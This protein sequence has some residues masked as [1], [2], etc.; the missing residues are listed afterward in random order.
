[1]TDTGQ[2]L[3]AN[4]PA[5]R[6]PVVE[7]RGIVKHF[8]GGVLA[9]DGIDLHL[10]RG[11][12]LGLLGEN[13][14][15]KTTLM[16]ILYGLTQPD[17]GEVFVRGKRVHF[18]SAHEAIAHGLGMVH[19]HFMLVPTFSVAENMAL[20]QP[21]PRGPLL[22]NRQAVSRRIVEL[23]SQYGLQTDP[24]AT[25]WQLSVGQQQHV[26]ILKA[27]YRGAE[28]L[29]LDEPTAVLTP[30]EVDELLV[31][32]R[33]LTADG[34]SLIFIS[35]KLRE[36]M[37][38]CDRIV[39]LRDGRLA[40]TVQAQE[41]SPAE[42]SRMMVGREVPVVT[43]RP[44]A[45][46]EARLQLRNLHVQ[47]DRGLPALRG[48]E[49]ALRAGEIVGIAGVEGNGQRELE[50]AISGVR[51]VQEG[52]ILLCEQDVTNATPGAILKAG[53]GHVPSDRYKMALVG[54]FSVAENLVLTTVARPPFT[55]RRLLDWEAIGAHAAKL[56]ETFAIR[57]PTLDTPAAN[58]SGGNAQKVVLARELTHQPQVLLVAQ[59]TR[60]VDI[61]AIEY[62][63]RE[64]VRQR[65]AGMAIL[66]I[67]TELEEILALSDRIVVLYEGRIVGERLADAS[68]TFVSPVSGVFTE[69]SAQQGTPAQ[70][71]LSA[72]VDLL[73][74]MMAG[75]ET[76]VEDTAA[77]KEVT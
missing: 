70:G 4:G 14:A 11:E 68:G 22:E 29:I 41:A 46:G 34:R 57:T 23:S 61:G 48:F 36:V 21:S 67:S 38:V 3:P 49:L 44:S 40:G 62:V 75:V 64:L 77:G 76:G 25:I 1:L 19:Q 51:P 35:H 32:L 45:P 54:D 27:L 13:G 74:L 72:S 60:G 31:I 2:T 58:L 52:Q 73:G 33:S 17:A 43:K 30:Q 66:L 42:L 12:I 24:D 47:D 39:V 28:I 18:R 16:N 9:N 69:R 50:E 59:P 5:A 65:D 26:E 53:L 37:A 7:M 6:Q 8:P 20:G 15:G 55:Q 71:S 63:H 56:V 10:H